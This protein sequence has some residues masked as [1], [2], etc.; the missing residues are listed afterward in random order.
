MEPTYNSAAESENEEQAVDFNKLFLAQLGSMPQKT[1]EDAEHEAYHLGNIG[2]SEI[3]REAVAIIFLL[4]G[5]KN[6][7]IWLQDPGN[8]ERAYWHNTARLVLKDFLRS[9]N[10]KPDRM[11]GAS[12]C[13]DQNDQLFMLLNSDDELF[14][15]FSDDAK[16]GDIGEDWRELFKRYQIKKVVG[17]VASRTKDGG[18]DIEGVEIIDEDL[19]GNRREE[20]FLRDLAKEYEMTT[21]QYLRF[22]TIVKSAE[23]KDSDHP[24]T[25]IQ[26][27]DLAKKIVAGDDSIL[28]K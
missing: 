14:D 25:A 10:L 12:V 9:K 27:H 17:R 23:A 11:T 7:E 1:G 21:T 20:G 16:E 22:R 24:G 19:M 28:V 2:I 4:E 3:R 26:Y 5:S 13:Q 8:S 15:L 6:L 18:I